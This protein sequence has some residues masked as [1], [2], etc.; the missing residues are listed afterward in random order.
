MAARRPVA[1]PS[2]RRRLARRSRRS[3]HS[4]YPACR[5]GS[6]HARSRAQPAA[7]RLGA[8]GRGPFRRRA[9]VAVSSRQR[10]SAVTPG[11]PPG[12]WTS[13][14][15]EEKLPHE[16]A[17]RLGLSLD[18]IAVVLALALALLVR[19]NVVHRVPW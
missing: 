19:F 4:M 6:A 15:P 12:E 2:L 1:G 17:P 10:R 5:P 16:A 14:M 18:T 13:P 9:A 7:G 3:T 11:N 8:A